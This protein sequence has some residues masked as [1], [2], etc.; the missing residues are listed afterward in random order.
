MAYEK[1]QILVTRDLDFPFPMSKYNP[2]GL[3]LLRVPDIFNKYEICNVFEQFLKAIKPAD[4][5]GNITVI[6][7]TKIRFRKL[8]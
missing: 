6:S 1:K 2:T 4:I 7:P 3:I 8:A 5:K